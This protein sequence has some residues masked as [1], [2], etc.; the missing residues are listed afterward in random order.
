MAEEQPEQLHDPVQDSVEELRVHVDN[1]LHVHEDSHKDVFKKD[2]N[3]GE[4]R[5]KI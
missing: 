3:L 1:L 2:F 4:Q 5:T